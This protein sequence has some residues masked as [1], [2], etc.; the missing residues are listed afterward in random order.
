MATRNEQLVEQFAS[1]EQRGRGWHVWPRP[2]VLEPAFRPFFGYDLS[3]PAEAATD[4][5]R[6]KTWLSA[7]AAAVWPW[8]RAAPSPPAAQSDTPDDE[9]EPQPAPEGNGRVSLRVLLP[10]DFIMRPA[11]AEQLVSALASMA[12]PVAF[13]FVATPGKVVLQINCDACDARYLRQQLA[14]FAPE[15]GLAPEPDLLCAA[16]DQRAAS[17]IAEFGLSHEFLRPL[18]RLSAFSVDPLTLLVGSLVGLEDGQVAV[19]QVIFHVARYPWGE[20]ALRGILGTDGRPLSIHA[21]DL[22]AQTKQ[23]LNSPLVAAVLRVGAQGS[24]SDDALM[25]LSRISCALCPFDVPLGQE[26]IPLSNDGYDD[27]AHER[28]LLG[29][30][31]HRSGM[32]LNVEELAALVHLPG[33]AVSHPQFVRFTTRTKEAPPATRG[34]QLVLGANAHLGHQNDVTLSRQQR[35]R[36]VY[37]IGAS[38]TG[39]STLLLSMIAQD[40]EAGNGLALLDPHGDLVDAVLARIPEHRLGDVVLIDPSDEA[41]PVGFNFLQAHSEL[42]RTIL[43]SDL[44]GVFRRLST[45]WGDQMNSVFAN[46]ILAILESSAGGTLL[47]LRRFLVD[48]KYRSDFLQT[49]ADPEIVY[50]W[51][52]E[53]PLLKGAPQAPILTRLDAFLRP[54]LIRNM[55]GQQ[56]SRL[57]FRAIMD[58]GR[59]VLAKLS[60]GAIGEENAHLLGAVLVAK[61]HQAALSRQDQE[62]S[63]RRDFFLYA[64]E[65]HHFTTPSMA[66][67]LSGVRKYGLGL[68][69]AHQDLQQLGGRSDAVASSVLNAATRIVFRVGDNDARQLAAGFESFEARDLQSLGIGEAI[70]RVERADADFNLTTVELPPVDAA[71]GKAR[72]DAARAASRARYAASTAPAPSEPVSDRPATAAPPA[73][74]LPVA[75]PVPA[76]PPPASPAAPPVLRQKPSPAPASTGRG[77]QQH[78]YLQTLIQKFGEDRGFRVSIEEP[79]LH[80]HGSVDVALT[81]GELRIAVEIT[82]TTPT[83]HELGNVAKCLAAGFDQ[84]V[85]VAADSKAVK[86]LTAAVRKALPP[87]TVTRVHCLG[88]SDVPLFLDTLALPQPDTQTVAG[89][90][91]RVQYGGGDIEEQ[92]ARAAALQGVIGRSIKRIGAPQKP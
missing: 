54:K 3:P 64:D 89:Y 51:Q 49:V 11:A 37:V 2:V 47:E 59:I 8:G 22:P 83:A 18:Q 84:V 69:L 82:I 32:L 15:V 76:P 61:L 60:H 50:Y 52:K 55:V 91:V 34:H 17:W 29:R 4:E 13:E 1:W 5:G 71:L 46:A 38:G 67:L 75:A 31:T 36:H 77:G 63:S 6:R 80:G 27:A 70:C 73:P 26:L 57:D 74:A 43:S 30:S 87:D 20:S 81:R 7:L 65:F 33:A 45:S 14:G 56:D 85:L 86:R 28:D 72:R 35:L 9:P 90:K 24:D 48:A 40:L 53:F 41:Y 39:K 79:V 44:V 25:L 68:T 10:R 23:K 78:K 88:A 42:E 62:A 92:R 19:L 16:W 66:S 21:P 12:Y 58:E